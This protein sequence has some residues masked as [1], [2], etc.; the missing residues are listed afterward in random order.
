MDN[1]E[2]TKWQQQHCAQC[3]D[4]ERQ[5]ISP[6]GNLMGEMYCWTGEHPDRVYCP[7]YTQTELEIEL[8]SR[9]EEQDKKRE[10]NGTESKVDR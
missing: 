8:E 9:I 6:N 1:E 10:Q 7:Y 4:H 3:S 2:Q 5:C